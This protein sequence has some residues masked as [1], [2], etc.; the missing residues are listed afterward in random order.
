MCGIPCTPSHK[1]HK[2][3]V[4]LYADRL[5][6]LSPYEEYEQSSFTPLSDVLVLTASTFTKLTTT[7]LIF[8]DIYSAE[9]LRKL[10]KM[11]KIGKNFINAL[12]RNMVFTAPFRDW[13]ITFCKDFLYR[14]SLKSNRGFSRWHCDCCGLHIRPSFLL[15][16]ERLI[17][18]MFCIF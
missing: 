2:S 9:F 10:T 5:Y 6:R 11:C 4:E 8:M 13:V 12:K 3:P 17:W 7:Q 16:K 18:L 14:F 15:Y 1:I